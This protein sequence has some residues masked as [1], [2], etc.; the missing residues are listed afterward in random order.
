[1]PDEQL[2]NDLADERTD[3][4]GERTHLAAERTQLAWWRTGLTSIAVGIGVGRILPVL[5][6]GVK[7]WPY[8]ALGVAFVLYG[9][10]LML[11]GNSL[12][13]KTG[14]RSDPSGTGPVIG[15]A[16]SS[17]GIVLGLATVLVILFAR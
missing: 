1:M 8:V 15:R 14:K 2:R 17:L 11:F 6:P 4:A 16:V 3:L 12:M 10:I 5:D 7:E 13:S 9:V